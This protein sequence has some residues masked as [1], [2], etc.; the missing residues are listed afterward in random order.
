M[1]TQHPHSFRIDAPGDL[2]EDVRA[3]LQQAYE[4][5]SGSPAWLGDG[6]RRSNKGNTPRRGKGSGD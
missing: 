4:L 3:W 1:P 5:G 6:T 2:D